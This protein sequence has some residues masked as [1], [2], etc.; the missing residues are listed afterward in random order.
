MYGIFRIRPHAKGYMYSRS[1]KWRTSLTMNDLY[2]CSFANISVS[3]TGAVNQL[4]QICYIHV[5]KVLV[6][7][8][9]CIKPTWIPGWQA[10]HS[11]SDRARQLP[12]G[13]L[14]SGSRDIS[15]NP[16]TAL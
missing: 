8:H 15:W 14:P 4:V 5:E 13:G 16:G 10:V 6:Y 3:N 1:L 12:E 11:S 2:E 7:S 9:L